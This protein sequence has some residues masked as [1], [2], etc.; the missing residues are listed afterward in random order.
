ML[1][2]F[3]GQFCAF[4]F[5]FCFFQNLSEWSPAWPNEFEL[6]QLI[7][8]LGLYINTES[9]HIVNVTRKISIV[10]NEHQPPSLFNTV[11]V[12]KIPKAIVFESNFLA[13][14]KS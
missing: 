6:F 11:K 2:I 7:F 8:H 10:Y 12:I 5:F 9:R 13:L 3:H 14:Y 4:F 1:L